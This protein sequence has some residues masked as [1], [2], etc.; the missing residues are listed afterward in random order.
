MKRPGT[1]RCAAGTRGSTGSSSSRCETTGIYCRPSCPA[2]TPKR[3]ER[4]LLRDRRGRPGLGFRACRRCRPDAVPGSAEWN[5]R[6]DVG[7]SG[8]AHDRRRRR[9]PRGRRRARRPARLQ[10][11]PGAAAAHRRG[12][13]RPRRAGPRPAGPHRARPARR[14]PACRSRRS[15]SRPGF[16]SVRQFNDTI[17]ADLRPTPSELRAAPAAARRRRGHPR[18]RHPAAARPP[19]PL[20]VRQPSSTC[21]PARPSPASRR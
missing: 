14:P 13:R 21:W 4:P 8:H 5:V 7:G 12:R 2:V 19:R 11:P 16:A 10:R 6:A 1:E 3:R 18:G 15:R 9:G 20:P 17:R